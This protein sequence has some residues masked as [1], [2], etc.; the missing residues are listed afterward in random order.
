[1]RTPNKKYESCSGGFGTGFFVSS[2]GYLVTNGHVASP[3]PIDG[4]I[5]PLITGTQYPAFWNDFAVDIAYVLSTEMGIDAR[6][7]S[8]QDLMLVVLSSFLELNDKGLI[9]ITPSYS[10]YVE[11]DTPFNIDR[12][13]F[14]PINEASL[15]STT[16]IDSQ[17]DSLFMID[18]NAAKN[19]QQAGI[20]TPDLAILKVNSDSKEYP[21]LKFSPLD[22]ITSGMSIHVLGFPGIADNSSFFATNASQIPT[23]TKGTISAVKPSTTGEFNMVQIDAAIS[24]GN[25]GG[26]ILNSNGEVVAVATYGMGQAGGNYNIGVSIEEVNKMLA[27]QG[28]TVSEGEITKY[29]NSGINNLE[30]AYY[31][32]AIKDLEKVIELYPEA[33][34]VITPLISIAKSKIEA[35]EDKTPIINTQS[36]EEKLSDLG[37]KV[38]GNTVL[39]AIISAIGLVISL[40]FVLVLLAFKRKRDRSQQPPIVGNVDT[41]RYEEPVQ[42]APS[43]VQPVVSQPMAEPVP[44]QPIQSSPV[45]ETPVQTMENTPTPSVV[46]PPVSPAPFAQPIPTPLVS[47]EPAQ[48]YQENS[49]SPPA[50]V[51]PFVAPTPTPSNP[52]IA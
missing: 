25:S 48:A 26:P 37:I 44:S 1:M 10:N 47:S 4:L 49:E 15:L 41:P 32:Y 5:I 20:K 27:D 14:L 33:S 16:L 36:I 12:Q 21:T 23:I 45:M 30:K 7:L 22:L 31:K 11:T 6:T 40:I 46:Q 42:V 2:D 52:P 18:Y 28:I 39:V 24:H 9:T 19:N 38:S 17:V 29:L 13:T 3:S 43:P 8:N 34:E 35:G 50:N 51:E